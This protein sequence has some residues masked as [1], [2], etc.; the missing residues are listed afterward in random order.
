[1]V[2]DLNYQFYFYSQEKGYSLVR[3][4]QSGLLAKFD[5]PLQKPIKKLIRKSKIKIDGEYSFIQ[6]WKEV[7]KAGYKVRF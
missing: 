7:E 6:A 1:M 2:Y 4:S 3:I 5:T